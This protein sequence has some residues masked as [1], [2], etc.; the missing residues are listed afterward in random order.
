[1]RIG[2]QFLGNGKPLLG[3]GVAKE[4]NESLVWRNEIGVGRNGGAEH[5]K[6]SPLP[7]STREGEKRGGWVICGSV[8]WVRDEKDI[9][10]GGDF[11]YILIL[12]L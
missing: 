9:R 2:K 8:W 3:N 6:T 4:G 10:D 12:Y 11:G 5:E 1:V 7:L